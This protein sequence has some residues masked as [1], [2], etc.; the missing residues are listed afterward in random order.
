MVVAHGWPRK[1]G[2]SRLALVFATRIPW[3][4][5][6]REALC[7]ADDSVESV[8]LRTIYHCIVMFDQDVTAGIERVEHHGSS[9]TQSD[10]ENR[11]VV[12]AP[13]FFTRGCVIL[14]QFQQVT[15]YWYSSWS[16]G[17]TLDTFDVCTICPRDK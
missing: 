17:Y 6:Y 3:T 16:L 5:S 11:L 9:V 4:A 8:K 14:P 7:T 15:E 1:S 10:L 13:P 2:S 12:L